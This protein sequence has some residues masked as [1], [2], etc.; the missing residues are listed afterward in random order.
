[1]H[2]AA[3]VVAAYLIGSIPVGVILSKL[4][5]KD[6]RKV[7][8]GNIGATNV[9]R[10]AGKTVGIITLLGDMAK[11]FIPT[12]LA[13]HAGLPMVFVVA[14]GFAAF[15]GH[16]FPVFLAFRGGKGVATALGVYLALNPLAIFLSFIIFVLVLLKW[17]YVSAGSLAGTA[18]M[19]LLLLALKSEPMYVYVSLV[20]GVFIFLKHLGNIKRLAAG[21]EHKLGSPR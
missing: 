8:S 16:L 5:G 13:L 7:G 18:A 17:R 12:L 9:M 20:I 3:Y 15:V 6:P 21:T 11:G 1:M 19:P 14:V 2:A 4:R 10:A